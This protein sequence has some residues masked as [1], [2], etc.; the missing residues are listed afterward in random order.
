MLNAIGDMFPTCSYG[1]RRI[2]ESIVMI[3]T[4]W[5]NVNLQQL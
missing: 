3:E 4:T 1:G 2:V 5:P